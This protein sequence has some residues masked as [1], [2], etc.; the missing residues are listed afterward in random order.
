[1]PRSVSD[2]SCRSRV[3]RCV[4]IGRVSELSVLD[5]VTAEPA[6]V[7]ETKPEAGRAEAN[8]GG[9]TLVQAREKV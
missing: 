9:L 7:A 4:F 1:M 2:E 3:V 5:M 6:G 8:C